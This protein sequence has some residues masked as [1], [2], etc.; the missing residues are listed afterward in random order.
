MNL[1][2]GQACVLPARTEIDEEA[3]VLGRAGVA[4]V[5]AVAVGPLYRDR[6]LQNSLLGVVADAGQLLVGDVR[7]DLGRRCEVDAFEVPEVVEVL[8]EECLEAAP[9]VAKGRF[10]QVFR[11]GRRLDSPSWSEMSGHLMASGC[12]IHRGEAGA[13]HVDTREGIDV[14]AY[15]PD[16]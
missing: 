3:H 6:R 10:V 8:R 12:L 16:A 7:D 11:R 14:S 1:D 2:R 13:A 9:I 15:D 4:Q 5:A